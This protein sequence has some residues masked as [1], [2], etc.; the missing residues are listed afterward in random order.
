MSGE[1]G[2]PLKMIQ[3]G[4]I[5]NEAAACHLGFLVRVLVIFYP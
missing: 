2:Q 1:D 4:G 3:S 5:C